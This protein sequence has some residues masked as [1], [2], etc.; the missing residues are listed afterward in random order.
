MTLT[1]RQ[2][3]GG[4]AAALALA[5]GPMRAATTFIPGQDV[6][7]DIIRDWA[8]E[9]T[10]RSGGMIRFSYF[11]SSQMGPADRQFD[12]VCKGV[13]D[14]SLLIHGNSP[15]RF[16]MTELAYLPGTFAITGNWRGN[17]SAIPAHR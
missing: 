5:A 10:A 17:A 15:A 2:V 1:R 4:T 6:L 14:I 13:A 16:P 3:F 11:P 7:V 12:M 9:V 8:D